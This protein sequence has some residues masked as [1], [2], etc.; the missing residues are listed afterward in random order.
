MLI[1]PLF[2]NVFAPIPDNVNV[3]AVVIPK[4]KEVEAAIVSTFETVV[5]VPPSV[6][7]LLLPPLIPK[8]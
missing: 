1:V 7:T 8:L 2:T 5:G 3:R 4:S 6:L